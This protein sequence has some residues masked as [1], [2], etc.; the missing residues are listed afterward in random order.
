MQQLNTCNN[1]IH[2]HADP[3]QEG[4]FGD[5]R[6]N[7]PV[8]M[9]QDIAG[10]QPGYSRIIYMGTWPAVFGDDVCSE[11]WPFPLSVDELMR[12]ART[13]AANAPIDTKAPRGSDTA[14]GDER[15]ITE[16]VN[17]INSRLTNSVANL[18][19]DIESIKAL[20]MKSEVLR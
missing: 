8:P 19:D 4:V 17:G 3:E 12:P 18:L 14:A 2:F 16:Q 9:P 10:S 20:I 11:F 1:C 6:K 7:A 5:C 13:E 15:S